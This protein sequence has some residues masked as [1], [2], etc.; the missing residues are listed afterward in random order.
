MALLHHRACH[1]L[2]HRQNPVTRTEPSPGGEAARRHAPAR[3]PRPE[4]HGAS[5]ALLAYQGV[6]SDQQIQI[7]GLPGAQSVLAKVALVSKARSAYGRRTQME[8]D[9]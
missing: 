9:R 3:Q 5:D 6:E 4:A 8:D 1:L 2:D 7:D